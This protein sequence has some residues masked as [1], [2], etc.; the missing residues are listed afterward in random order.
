MYPLTN[1]STCQTACDN[2]NILASIIHIPILLLFFPLLLFLC[3]KLINCSTYQTACSNKNTLASIIHIPL[4]FLFIIYII[5]ITAC[6]HLIILQMNYFTQH[7]I[8]YP[9]VCHQIIVLWHLNLFHR[10]L[11]LLP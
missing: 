5:I 4:L 10:Y 2:K 9:C 3:I 7:S 6:T 1:C 11:Q 8:V